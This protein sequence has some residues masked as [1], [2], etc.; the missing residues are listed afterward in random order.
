MSRRRLAPLVFVVALLRRPLSRS[1]L[2]R[3]PLLSFAGSGTRRRTRRRP[4]RSWSTD[5]VSLPGRTGPGTGASST[6]C[7][8]H[9]PVRAAGDGEVV[10][11]GSVAGSL[12][13]TVAHPDGLRTSYSFLTTL[14]V[15]T[16]CAGAAWR[17]RG[18]ERCTPALRRA[19]PVGSVSRSDDALRRNGKPSRSSRARGSR[20][21]NRRCAPASGSGSYGWCSSARMPSW[22]TDAED[23]ALWL[24]YID[25]LRVDVRVARFAGDL[26]HLLAQQR[27]CT[28]PSVLPPPPTERRL[29]R[30]RRRS[31]LDVGPCVDRRRRRAS[32]RRLAIGRRAVLLRRWTAFPT[33]PTRSTS[34]TSRPTVTRPPTPTA[35]SGWPQVG[36]KRSCHDVARAAPGVPID[37]VAHSQGGV[38]AR[39]AVARVP[40]RAVGCRPRSPRWPRSR[41]P[42]TASTWPPLPT[43]RRRR[44]RPCRRSSPRPGTGRRRRR[45]S[46]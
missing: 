42:S 26:D 7:T 10:F 14:E 21:A 8:P 38:V 3:Q 24:H 28:A 27:D 32:A 2:C 29:A 43:R 46:S 35:I 16:G 18:D 44:T 25:E 6:R 20:K 5:S 33:T 1:A 17:C 34:P 15:A 40:L 37:L 11:A 22:V 30:A 13:L 12:H 31:R 45:S 36:W 23:R 4:T 19:R 39:L 41:R 9:S